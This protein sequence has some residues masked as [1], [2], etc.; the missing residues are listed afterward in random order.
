M[1]GATMATLAARRRDWIK[2]YPDARDLRHNSKWVHQRRP[3]ALFA[4]FRILV[5][6]QPQCRW[7]DTAR[8]SYSGKKSMQVSVTSER[9]AGYDSRGQFLIECI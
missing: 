4:D 7:A 5:F 8:R 6:T 9:A 2:P 1:G 3:E